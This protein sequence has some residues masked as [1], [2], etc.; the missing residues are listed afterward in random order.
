MNIVLTIHVVAS[1]YSSI[2]NIRIERLWRDVRK[3]VLEYYR[4]LFMHLEKYGHLNMEDAIHRTALFL[5]YQPQVQAALHRATNAWN[6]HHI[7]TEQANSPQV[8]WHLSRSKALR[9][10]YWEDPGDAVALASDPYYGVDGQGPMPPPDDVEGEMDEGVRVHDDAHLEAA[11][12]L[13]AA[14]GI[15]LGRNDGNR[16]MDVYREVVDALYFM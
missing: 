4:L 14:R 1:I 5:V 16:S 12:R 11:A 6:V 7:R 10:G 8:L 9:L 2:H 15:D 3:D 13:I